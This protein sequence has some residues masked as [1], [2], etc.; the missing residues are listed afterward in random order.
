MGSLTE[1]S[2][3]N[4]KITASE[5]AVILP[6]RPPRVEEFRA[7]RRPAGCFLAKWSARTASAGNVLRAPAK[8][9]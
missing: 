7:S 2:R 4:S 5:L 8:H 3:N 9:S 1:N 6:G